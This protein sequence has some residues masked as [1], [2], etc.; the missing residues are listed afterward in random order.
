MQR[1]Y[2]SRQLQPAAK[3]LVTAYRKTAADLVKE[4]TDGLS[5]EF[6]DWA[7]E[8]EYVPVGFSKNDPLV[9]NPDYTK[10]MGGPLT[11]WDNIEGFIK[12]RYPAAHRG[13]RYGEENASDALDGRALRM[14]AQYSPYPNQ[15]YHPGYETGP[16]AV[17]KYGYDPRQVAAGFM[18]LHTNAH[19]QARPGSRGSHMSRDIDRLSDI[20]QKRQQMQRDYEKRQ[21]QTVTATRYLRLAGFDPDE[22]TSRLGDEFAEWHAGQPSG[23]GGH[24]GLFYWPNI[25]NFLKEKYPAAHRGFSYGREQAGEVLDDRAN[26]YHGPQPYDTDYSAQ[27][28]LGYDP[29]EIAAG[30]LLLHNQTNGSSRFRERG[31]KQRLVNIFD[32]RQQMQRNYE[33]QQDNSV[34]TAMAWQDW[35]PRIETKSL[36]G[37]EA[38]P[39]GGGCDHEYG[40]RSSYKIYH[41][42][43]ND[44]YPS[45]LNYSHYHAPVTKEP[46]LGINMLY[47]NEDHRNDGIAEALMRRLHE[48]HPGVRIV[49]GDMSNQGKAFHDKMLQKEP[50]ARDLVTARMLLAMAWDEWSPLIK[51]GCDDGCTYSREGTDGRYTIPQAGAFLDYYHYNHRGQDQ[52]AVSGIYTHPSNRGDGVAEALMRRLSEDHPGVPINPGVMTRDGQ[53]F[54]DRMLQ[55]DPAAR[56]LITARRSPNG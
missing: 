51:G 2:D 47:A 53:G 32:R 56:D 1:N 3:D 10:L 46:L 13:Y 23:N 37:N 40:K 7:R 54:H 18:Y 29:E 48:D 15:T 38:C 43:T 14:P 36:Y 41:E 45:Y 28:S 49:P 21:K 55:K 16:E 35:A 9:I 12:D 34:K 33:Q 17:E 30:M 20:F 4:Y 26:P 22:V 42:G 5:K 6:H 31:D 24:L 50:A 8:Q 19:E 39:E 52:V 44:P 27:Q 11:Y 25:E